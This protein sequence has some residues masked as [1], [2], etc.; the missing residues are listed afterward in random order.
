[1]RFFNWLLL[2]MFLSTIAPVQSQ[3]MRIEQ[4]YGLMEQ[5]DWDGAAALAALA[6]EEA[7]DDN[8]R[9]LAREVKATIN[10]YLDDSDAPLAELIELNHDAI[11]LFGLIDE[12]RLPVLEL[13]GNMYASQGNET[14]AVRSLTQAVRIERQKNVDPETLH[15]GLLNLAWT[16][17]EAGQPETAAIIASELSAITA[18]AYGEDDEIALEAGLIR[19]FSHLELG[20]PIEAVVHAG[21][22]L[23]V[24][25]DWLND[26]LPDV[27]DLLQQFFDELFEHA[28]Q[29][30]VDPE[31]ILD[32]WTRQA[33]ELT[34]IRTTADADLSGIENFQKAILAKNVS[35]SDRIARNLTERV[36][37]DD[38]T[39]A[40]IYDVIIKAH[41]IDK[42]P[43]AALAW[44]QRL[45]SFP[46]GYLAA[47]EFDAIVN[48]VDVA[49]WLS[50]NGRYDEA[51]DF[52]NTAILIADLQNGPNAKPVQR[53]WIERINLLFNADRLAETGLEIDVA[54]AANL[55]NPI[56]AP[57]LR[58][59]MFLLL[60]Q[61]RMT[62]KD[63]ESAGT[64]FLEAAD[65]LR[66]EN[67][68][69]DSRW[70][71]LLG[72]WSLVQTQL[73]KHENAVDLAR[74]SL[75][76]HIQQNG[77]IN[78]KT[79]VAQASL[80]TA[81][82]RSGQD[83]EALEVIENARTTLEDNTEP[84]SPYRLPIMLAHAKL[85][86]QVGSGNQAEKLY[87]QAANTVA[88]WEERPNSNVTT[89]FAYTTLAWNAWSEDRLAE[90]EK[91][92]GL[93]VLGLG[94]DD[95][96]QTA[97]QAL[98]GRIEL[99]RGRNK[100]ALALFREVSNTINRPGRLELLDA[101][102]HFPLHIEAALRQA[103]QTTGNTSTDFINEAFLIAQQV[104]GLSVGNTLQR[105]SSRW[106]S[107]PALAEMIRELQDIEANIAK[108]N[109]E[110]TEVIASGG[111]GTK[112]DARLDIARE[113]F[114]QVQN[115]IQ[116]VSPKFNSAAFPTPVEL[117]D[118]GAMLG[119][120]EVLVMFATSNEDS[121][122]GLQGSAIM[123]V[124]RERVATGSTV[125][126]ATLQQISQRLRC[127]AALTD[128]NCNQGAGQTRGSFSLDTPVA[129]TAKSAVSK[130]DTALAHTAYETV[131]GPVAEIFEGKT[132]LI[133]V[134]D[135][136]LIAL[137]FHLL[138]RSP[139]T[140]DAPLQS[141][142]WLIRDMSV[143]VVPT[144]ASLQALRS[145]PDR[146]NNQVNRFL[147]I[148]DPLIGSQVD[149]AIEFECDLGPSETVFVASLSLNDDQKLLRGDVVDSKALASLRALPETRC[150]LQQSIRHFDESSRL[151]LQDMATE[152]Q[153]RD[154]SE[155]GELA[156][157]RTLSFAT[158]GLIA[159]EIGAENAGLVLSPT[160]S[161]EPG[162]DGL[163]TTG[164]IAELKLDADIVLLSACNT[165]AGN[166]D[167]SEGLTGLANAFFYAGAR[168]LMVS[169]WPVYSDAS[170]EITT[171]VL[172]RVDSQQGLGFAE[173]LRQ[174]MLAILDDPT[175]EARK[176]HPSYWAPF[177]IVGEGAG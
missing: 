52:I 41:L 133:V 107:A 177:M 8:A 132:K 70:A 77:L 163:L 84:N 102:D 58:A 16:Y 26:T 19:A 121:V 126:R 48:F 5:Q 51:L 17:L 165:A 61:L 74:K 21:P 50:E 15:F 56:S 23:S 30:G 85:L 92:A 53:L 94:K 105:A 158:H 6:L 113:L 59:E 29:Q 139:P 60:G 131:L 44:A 146:K 32:E 155:S 122:A 117:R 24:D 134:P 169:H 43:S 159:G 65:L 9:Y 129:D 161:A 82:F 143:F 42:N 4:A 127:E 95:P 124:T 135:Q 110:F 103:A 80:A 167:S 149:G 108:L 57:E 83:R 140:K 7:A 79:L 175:L 72:S 71:D 170:A 25:L 63:M 90:S 147:G 156:G 91:F 34:Q 144:V 1:M 118:V 152:A 125:S 73:G 173:A 47:V 154:M 39:T 162:G 64:Q 22:A 31:G 99:E 145:A 18:F 76:L 123:A 148:G 33:I 142:D 3:D 111:D 81:L 138:V 168:S 37:S 40:Q 12:R 27:F 116:S 166:R 68:T 13:L 97:M 10:Y 104:N 106:E 69:D 28:V 49:Q 54:L 101:R 78:E 136:A 128:P 67:L 137:P 35:Q 112:I 153:L 98:R 62:Q 55:A 75:E 130:F 150:E 46:I 119:P 115:R 14:E 160:N 96:V 164:E 87:A 88:G 66:Q 114:V 89:G 176:Q 100:A 172:A 11:I 171:S 151:L 2:A 141:V 45:A 38:P 86:E 93:A 120:D 157:F 174:T 20:H 36:L 109:Q